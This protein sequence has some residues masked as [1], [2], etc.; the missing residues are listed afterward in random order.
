M[1]R[2]I[3][4]INHTEFIKAQDYADKLSIFENAKNELH[5]YVQGSDATPYH[6]GLVKHPLQKEVEGHC[7]CNAF[8]H[9]FQ[10][11]H[12]AAVITFGEGEF[13]EIWNSDYTFIASEDYIASHK[14]MTS[15]RTPKVN[16]KDIHQNFLREQKYLTPQVNPES[17]YRQKAASTT[18]PF[19]VWYI[20]DFYEVHNG[21]KIN[22]SL[23]CQSLLKSGKLGKMKKVAISSEVIEHLPHLEDREILSRLSSFGKWE[24]SYNKNISSFSLGNFLLNEQYSL[25]IDI[26]KTRRA[27]Y[28]TYDHYTGGEEHP[29][30]L[31]EQTA[32]YSLNINSHQ[33]VITPSVII[34]DRSFKLEE[35]SHFNSKKLVLKNGTTF[36]QIEEKKHIPEAVLELIRQCN[37]SD[38]QLSDQEWSELQASV[39]KFVPHNLFTGDKFNLKS[40]VMD[41]KFNLYLKWEEGTQYIRGLIHIPDDLTHSSSLIELK[42]DKL[43]TF[44]NHFKEFTYT[45]DTFVF[46][47]GRLFDLCNYADEFDIPV[48]FR[49]QKVNSSTSFNLDVMSGIDWLKLDPKI[50]INKKNIDFDLI[51]KNLDVNTGVVK[52]DK[53]NIGILPKKWINRIL[54]IQQHAQISKSEVK[55]HPAKAL[56][57]EE[58]PEIKLELP[59][60]IIDLKKDLNNFTKVKPLKAD[61]KFNGTLRPYQELALGWFN[62]LERCSFGGCLADDMGLGKTIQ[63]IA[64]F[65]KKVRKNKDFKALILCPKSL[66]T[67]WESEIHKFAPNI[68]VT[69]WKT[70]KLTNLDSQITIA[71]YQLFQRQENFEFEF[72]YLVLDEA[73]IIKNPNAR[74]HKAVAKIYAQ[75]KLALTGTPVE[76]HAGDL[77]S[78]F[79][80][81]IPSLFPSKNIKDPSKLD[82]FKFLRP[83]I[84]RR[85]KEEVLTELPEKNIQTIYCEQLVSEKKKYLNYHLAL[86]QELESEKDITNT[87]FTLLQTLTKLRQAACHISLIEKDSEIPSSKIETL[88]ELVQ[89]IHE[90]GHK[91][92]IFSQ[93]TRLLRIVQSELELNGANSC[94]LDGQTT[95]REEVIQ[96]FKENNEKKTF[97]ISIKSGGVGL[98]LTN[99]SY[100]IILDPWWNPAVEA[101]AIDRIHR[102]GQKNPVFAY[103]L[104]TK[105]TIEEKVSK[106][107]D[108]KKE[109][110]KTILDSNEGFI[111]EL[112]KNDINF[113]L[114]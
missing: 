46:E 99:A 4:N 28:R 87:K 97:L 8:E 96:Q 13:F 55:L 75:N 26:L 91:V 105:D 10:C 103:R 90:S 30:E 72:D 110:Y 22:F 85:T 38:L 14:E 94:Y 53:K 76:N 74:T 78:I 89:E 71:S 69:N 17:F 44:L 114:S 64:H 88:K 79:N 73:Q 5:A 34:N 18:T 29:L 111:K 70:G 20:I 33:K 23:E 1:K 47:A 9:N 59:K 95:K 109:L 66:T 39:L 35:F 60:E 54:K 77:M 84:L 113:L 106:L 104:I 56:L 112:S 52:L 31:S 37:E 11:K 40:V 21:M 48:F 50:K 61:A 86:K 107:Q 62:F 67:N 41:V 58:F 108:K 80:I 25:F 3:L 101:Q 81:I 49:D 2:F 7:T 42:Y 98:N 32:A 15:T 19:H 16:F 63:V 83:F 68:S 36:Y 92:I 65:Q 100:C 102:I 24:H 6:V 93:F 43:E 82:N 27:I 51:L 57:L 45:E 12:I